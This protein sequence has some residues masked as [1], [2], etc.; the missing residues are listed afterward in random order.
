[1][2]SHICRVNSPFLFMEKEKAWP[3]EKPACLGMLQSLAA[4]NPPWTAEVGACRD[5]HSD[6]KRRFVFI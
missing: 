1:L 3:K 6:D 2:A 5:A 4:S